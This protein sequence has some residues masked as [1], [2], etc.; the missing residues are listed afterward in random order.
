M[1]MLD[2]LLGEHLEEVSPVVL[3]KV[4]W[5][6]PDLPLACAAFFDSIGS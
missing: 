1:L 6:D 4:H 5:P 2:E 3:K